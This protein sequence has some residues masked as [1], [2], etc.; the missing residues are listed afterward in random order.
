MRPRF[1]LGLLIALW[2]PGAAGAADYRGKTVNLYIGY[3]F[4]GTYGAYARLFADYLRSH[5]PGEPTVIVQSMPG[6]GGIRL[7]NFAANAMPADGTHIFV[8]PDTVVISQLLQYEGAKYDA[9]KFHYIGGSEQTN[10]VWVVRADTGGRTI[11]DL[12]TIEIASGHSG[13]GS[14]A[15]MIPALA[16]GLLGLK[17][18]L[19]AGYEGSNKVILAIEQGE[20]HAAALNWLAWEVAVPQWFDKAKPF[21]IPVLQVGLSP[22]PAIPEVPMLSTMAAKEDL[23]LINF[24][25]THGIIGRSLA[26]PPGT[27]RENVVML[28]ESF[29]AMLSDTAYLQDA[30][31]RRLRVIP[32]TGEAL[33]DAVKSAIDNADGPVLAKARA[34]L[35]EKP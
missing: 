32:S 25:A 16:K 11:A 28:R 20:L 2:L 9:R 4:G 31:K 14:T 30:A 5:I 22:D 6:A 17:V 23:P 33:Q 21:A 8:P 24:I 12:K 26:A 3:G 15:F 1:L 7:L 35:F 29:A 10:M 13:P 27:P 34:I 18:K 19:I